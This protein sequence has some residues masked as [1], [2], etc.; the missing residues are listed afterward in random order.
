ML[1][2]FRFLLSFTLLLS[3]T[4]SSQFSLES[5]YPSNFLQKQIILLSNTAEALGQGFI[6]PESDMKA[7]FDSDQDDVGKLL[8]YINHT[9]FYGE[10]ENTNN[11]KNTNFTNQGGHAYLHYDSLAKYP[12]DIHLY[13]GYYTDLRLMTIL[14]D[15][16]NQSTF[17]NKTNGYR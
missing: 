16:D 12:F 14:Y 6:Q 10:W 17:Y 2:I 8:S 11:S 3:P 15:F 7:S 9:Y 13:D 5:S 1:L 4:F